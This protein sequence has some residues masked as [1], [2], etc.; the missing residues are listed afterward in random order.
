MGEADLA[1]NWFRGKKEQ[2]PQDYTIDDLIVLERYDEAEA[3]L[4][5]RLKENPNDLHSHLKLAEVC[6]ELRQFE[7][8]VDE[9]VYVAEEYAQDGFHEKGIALLSKAM[10]LAPLDQTLR[11]KV[12]KLQREKSMEHVRSLAL[13]GLRQAG[14][15]QAGTSALELKRLWHNL[16]TSTLVQRL[17]GSGEQLKRLFSIMQLVRYEPDTVLVREGSRDAFLLLIVIGVVEAAAEA[18]GRLMTVRSFT[19]GDMVGEGV[20]LERGAWPA[21]YRTAEQV[22][23]LKLTREGLEQCLVGNPDPRGF[24]EALREQHNDRDVL[25]TVRRLRH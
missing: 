22:T 5:A 16:A 9:Y 4:R 23:A 25:A 7:K 20:L 24:L 14:G 13:E 19:S 3:R 1:I 21:D 17:A 2:E 10:K 11:F 15:T 18:G 8:A 6:T 12:E